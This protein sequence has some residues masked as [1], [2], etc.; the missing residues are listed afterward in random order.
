MTASLIGL[1]LMVGAQ[2]MSALD[3][4]P[5]PNAPA[6]QQPPAPPSPEAAAPRPGCDGP[7]REGKPCAGAPKTV[8]CGCGGNCSCCAAC[9]SGGPCRCPDPCGCCE[10]ARCRDGQGDGMHRQ[11]RARI[12]SHCA[13]AD[14]ARGGCGD[15]RCGSG[16]AMGRSAR[17][18]G[19]P[20]A[21]CSG[22]GC[23]DC[24]C[25]DCRRGARRDDDRTA[26]GKGR[27]GG[28]NPGCGCG[29]ACD[30]RCDGRCGDCARQAKNTPCRD[31]MMGCCSDPACCSGERG[32][33]Q[34]GCGSG[35]DGDCAS[36]RTE[37]RTARNAPCPPSCDRGACG[38]ASNRAANPCGCD[39]AAQRQANAGCDC[40]GPCAPCAD[41][42][43]GCGGKNVRADREAPFREPAPNPLPRNRRAA[44]QPPFPYEQTE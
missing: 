27:C 40:T 23:R 12:A 25:D 6:V 35:C 19:C 28:G 15:C 21:N 2:S 16:C 44:I 14:C 8:G 42:A 33:A 41:P 36:A 11:T 5:C 13:D 37:R 20:D 34:R 10:G 3:T 22:S 38:C 1:M 7:C 31:A 9:K 32:F 18:A 24:R 29:G 30:G 26:C 4:T 17:A 43:C 39:R